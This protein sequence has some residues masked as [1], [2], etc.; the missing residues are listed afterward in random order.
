MIARSGNLLDPLK[1][2]YSESSGRYSFAEVKLRLE[3]LMNE[4][5]EVIKRA[6]SQTVKNGDNKISD[7]TTKR[8]NDLFM[9]MQDIASNRK[10]AGDVE[11]IKGGV[12]DI[13]D[14]SRIINTTE[15][16]EFVELKTIADSFEEALKLAKENKV[17]GADQLYEY[18]T[19]GITE[20]GYNKINMMGEFL[21]TLDKKDMSSKRPGWTLDKELRDSLL[22]YLKEYGK[23]GRAKRASAKLAREIEKKQSLK[24]TS[25]NGTTPFAQES[26]VITEAAGWINKINDGKAQISATDLEILKSFMN[27]FVF[28]V[29]GL[30]DEQKEMGTNLVDPLM[31]LLITMRNEAKQN[32]N[33]ALSDEIRNKL[34]DLGFEIKDGKEGSSY[35]IL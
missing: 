31:Q 25:E 22:P 35:S 17:Q 20:G 8:L 32:K 12:K 3:Y 2:I 24:K 15:G 29:L 14:N 34:S 5:Q 16:L 19:K 7:N 13:A 27:A 30:V 23:E 10:F 6:G 9:E 11:G 18:W 4:M 26:E 33:F 21:E 28:D 1:E